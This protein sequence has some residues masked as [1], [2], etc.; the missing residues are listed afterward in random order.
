MNCVDISD[1]RITN[2]SCVTDA[3]IYD[4]VCVGFSTEDYNSFCN[5]IHETLKIH[6]KF[7]GGKRHGILI[8]VKVEYN[9]VSGLVD[10][11]YEYTLYT[12]KY[13]MGVLSMSCRTFIEFGE[14]VSKYEKYVRNKSHK[15]IKKYEVLTLKSFEDFK[16]QFQQFLNGKL[17]GLGNLN[18]IPSAYWFNIKDTHETRHVARMNGEYNVYRVS[19][20]DWGLFLLW[21]FCDNDDVIIEDY[22]QELVPNL[23][24]F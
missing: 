24:R 21:W 20:A 8:Q 5:R 13:T 4:V 10:G 12:S 17:G 3:K 18:I 1:N 19:G 15:F 7:N 6:V 23:M 11:R 2:C 16:N 14:D 9:T 22:Y